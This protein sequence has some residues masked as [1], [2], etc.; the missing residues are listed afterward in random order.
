MSCVWTP[1]LHKMAVASLSK[2][3]DH[4]AWT[5]DLGI[6]DDD[7]LSRKLGA[8]Q[9]HIERLLGFNIEDNF[10]GV[11][12]APVPDSLTEAVL[13]LA[14]HWYDNREAGAEVIRELPFGVR[15]LVNEYREFTF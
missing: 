6:S 11:D 3:K 5:S 12:Q 10:G 4:L 7:L 9:D 8:A 13:Q 14:A 1:W 15:D 2:F